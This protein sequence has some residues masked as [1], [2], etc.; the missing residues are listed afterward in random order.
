MKRDRRN[1]ANIGATV[2]GRKVLQEKQ[3]GQQIKHLEMPM[4][5]R[6]EK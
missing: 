6:T 3:S 1:F 5:M 2:K 4:K